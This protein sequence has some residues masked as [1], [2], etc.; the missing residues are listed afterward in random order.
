VGI[1]SLYSLER[2]GGWRM[3]DGGPAGGWRS[4]GGRPDGRRTGDDGDSPFS[5]QENGALSILVVIHRHIIYSFHS[6]NKIRLLDSGRQA[7]I[8]Q[9]FLIFSKI[10]PFR[11]SFVKDKVNSK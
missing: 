5:R 4:G 1:I 10:I 8:Q 11:L 9:S 3:E 2:G 7:D 6:Y